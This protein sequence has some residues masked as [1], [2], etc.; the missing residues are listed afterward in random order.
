MILANGQRT[1]FKTCRKDKGGC[2]KT[3]RTTSKRALICDECKKRRAKERS[4][5]ITEKVIQRR[6]DK[7]MSE[8]EIILDVDALRHRR[9]LEVIRR[10]K[11]R[12]IKHETRK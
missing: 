5:I 10:L 8:E 7:G 6:L 2:G 12:G 11:Q 3:H 9:K 4:I 1:H